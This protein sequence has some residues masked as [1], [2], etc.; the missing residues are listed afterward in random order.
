VAALE[1]AL[2]VNPSNVVS[3]WGLY[4]LEFMPTQ[5]PLAI[6]EFVFTATTIQYIAHHRPELLSWMK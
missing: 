1:I 5:I 3:F 4:T 6:V 2:S